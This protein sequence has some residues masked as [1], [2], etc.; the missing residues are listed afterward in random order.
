MCVMLQCNKCNCGHG[1]FDTK[2]NNVLVLANELN[3]VSLNSFVMNV[4]CYYLSVEQCQLIIW[5]TGKSAEEE[6]LVKM[7]SDTSNQKNVGIKK[8]LNNYEELCYPE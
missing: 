5:I 8:E 4:I 1:H 3:E 6:R 2:Q 7:R